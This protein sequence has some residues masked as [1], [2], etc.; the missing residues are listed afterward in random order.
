M[1]DVPESVRVWKIGVDQD[2]V[3]SWNNYKANQGYNLLCV[4][5][6]KFLTYQDVAMGINL[7]FKDSGDNK[8]HFRLPDNQE[9]EI[10]SGE[11]VSLGIGGDPSFLYYKEQHFGI[12]LAYSGKPE[13][14]WRIFGA[15][16]ELGKPIPQNTPIALLN[17]KVKP[18][19]DFLI[20]FQR[21]AG[22]TDIGW[23][24]SPGFWDQVGNFAEKHAVDA[25]KVVIAAL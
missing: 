24:T 5:N 11:A 15:D 21:P 2:T 6:G 22:A 16:T 7:A 23:T 18:G 13:A 14:E 8:T 10:L 1:T 25:V 17:D 9:R 12:N 4:T 20:K 3:R 19:A